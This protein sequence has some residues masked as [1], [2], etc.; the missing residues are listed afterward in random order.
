M[1][2]SGFSDVKVFSI[3]IHL[4]LLNLFAPWSIAQERDLRENNIDVVYIIPSSH[5]DLGFEKPPEDI[6]HEL[7][8][9][10]DEIIRNARS[11]PQF[12]FTIEDTWHV[13]EWHKRTT[14]SDLVNAFIEI[15]ERGQVEI[16][17]T[18]GSMH[19]EF[20]GA[21]A[22]NR[23]VYDWTRLSNEIGIN[24][25]FAM[26]NDVPGFTGTL[27]QV[28]AKSGVKYFVNG[29][30]LGLGIGGGTSLYPA[31]VPFYWESK[32]GS[33]V[34]MWETQG[35]RG[36][37][38]EAIAEYWLD[39]RSKDPYQDSHF[40]P[41]EYDNLTELEIMQVGV[42]KLVSKYASAGY[43]YDALMILHSHDF[44]SSDWVIENLIPSVNE[45]NEAG[46]TPRIEIATPAQFFKHL[47]EKY[48]NEFPVYQGDWSGL[49]SEA[50]INSPGIS[51]TARW[52]YTHPP[53]AEILWTILDIAKG[54]FHPAL[55]AALNDPNL[56]EWYRT[57]QY[58]PAGNFSA[59]Y[60]T[61]NKYAEHSGSGQTGWPGL[62]TRDQINEQNR[63][64][65]D[66]VPDTRKTVE[67]LP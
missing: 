6:L 61:L 40:Y 3:F 48:G 64:Y 16:S 4:L 19:S 22:L 26:M 33:R 27:P 21:E 9:H 59:C 39:P 57:W 31:Q 23:L 50:K 53:A 7:K 62:M 51:A 67:D 1:H 47:E 18:F 17:M 13:M 49:W 43:P 30:N 2:C 11:D 10:V 5:Y 63:Q 44:V 45:W 56:G 14:D 65:V 32:D 41:E 37:Y 25:N 42:N 12:R 8:P 28:L 20:M 66:Y 55:Q 58:Y 52:C 54:D 34:L 38:T 29:S 24:S 60:Y 15:V 35:V 36:G 46:L